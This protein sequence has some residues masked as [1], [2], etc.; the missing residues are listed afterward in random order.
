M[1]YSNAS[2]YPELSA[3]RAKLERV[4]GYASN[5]SINWSASS[6][7]QKTSW[8]GSLI[9]T[10]IAGVN[11][12]GRVG[13]RVE[14]AVGEAADVLDGLGVKVGRGE[15]VSVEDGAMVGL[16]E[17]GSEGITLG[18]TGEVVTSGWFE[19]VRKKIETINRIIITPKPANMMRYKGG[20]SDLM[21]G[22]GVSFGAEVIWMSDSFSS[23]RDGDKHILRQIK[24]ADDTLA[25]GVLGWQ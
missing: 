12:G 8:Y 2:K 10:G 18:K 13:I 14:V 11:D 24:L 3:P 20:R 15:G 21:S 1:A 17:A 16:G 4:S 25:N 7:V 6:G 9:A 5:N 22:G 23:V 19:R